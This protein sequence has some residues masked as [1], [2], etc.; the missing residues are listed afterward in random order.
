MVVFP[1]V[2]I[3]LPGVNP[4]ESGLGCVMFRTIDLDA[5]TASVTTKVLLPDVTEKLPI[6]VYGL[7]PPVAE[8]TTVDVPPLHNIFVA[9][10]EADK[11]EAGSEITIF[12]ANV[13]GLESRM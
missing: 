5:P 13:Q 4:N 6:P 8:T 11:V 9:V 10:A 7:L 1:P 3:I 2:T 12:F